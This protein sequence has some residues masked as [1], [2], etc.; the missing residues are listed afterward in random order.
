MSNERNLRFIHRYDLPRVI[1]AITKQINIDMEEKDDT[2]SIVKLI[3]RL[4]I[5]QRIEFAPID[6]TQQATEGVIGNLLF[7]SLF[8]AANKNQQSFS[9]Y[10]LIPMPCNQGNQRVKLAQTPH[11]IG[12]SK[13][14][15][16]LIQWTRK[17]SGAC[18]FISMSSCRETPP[19][20]RSWNHTCLFEILTD[21]NLTL[22]RIE[23]EVEQIF[24]QRVSQQ[25][26]TLTRNETKCHR[27]TQLEQ[28]Q[29]MIA[30]NNELTIPS[31]ALITID[32]S[33]AW[34]CDNF[35]LC[36]IKNGTHEF[37]SIIDNRKLKHDN[38]NLSDLNKA[39]SNDTRWEKNTVHI[40]KQK[41]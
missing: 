17:E 29:H 25:W 21:A 16:E 18:K 37:I 35:F 39:M 31:V 33:T 3:N 4:L 11:V 36:G 19:I 6:T 15:M 22:C 14:T 13:R 7:I 23:H 40:R 20:N 30:A 9:T 28:S 34:S 12:I 5:Q 26:A 38:S 24:M 32:K 41:L 2:L 8:A 10:E 1:K 27:V